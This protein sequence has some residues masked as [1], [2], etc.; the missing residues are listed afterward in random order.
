[1]G[2]LLI[3]IAQVAG[4]AV[5][6]MNP[7]VPVYAYGGMAALFL[8]AV[9]VTRNKYVWLLLASSLSFVISMGA[10]PLS[11]T[12][13]VDDV[14]AYT[15]NRKVAISG[16]IAGS[17]EEYPDREKI[18]LK[19]DRLDNGS[20]DGSR[21]GHGC[22]IQLFAFRKNSGAAHLLRGD[23]VRMVTRL[24]MPKNLNNPGSF[25]YRDSLAKKGI[26]LVAYVN[27]R[28]DIAIDPAMA[29]PGI[30]RS[31]DGARLRIKDVIAKNTGD[32]TVSGIVTALVIGDQGY[33]SRDIRRMFASTGIIH[34]LVVA[35][36]HLAIITH[37]FY[38]LTKFL[39]SRSAYLCG[40]TAIPKLALVM[41]MIPMTAYIFLSGANPPV[42][43]SGIMIAVYGFLFL[44]NKTQTRWTG[45]LVAAIFIL[46]VNP[47]A[48]Y[49][50]SFQLSF[51]AV[52]SI[53]ACMPVITAIG[54]AVSRRF[55]KHGVREIVRSL[56]GMLLI[57]F[58]VT[59]G[60]FGVIAFYFNTL[61]LFGI[62]LNLIV[63][64]F[65]CYL[66]LPLSLI[67]S[68]TGLVLPWFSHY[69]FMIIAAL[70]H[71]IVEIV[72]HGANLPIASIRVPT[73][74]VFEIF[75]YYGGM[76]ILLN[77][78]RMGP[79]TALS[80]LFFIFL[81][82][83]VDIGSFVSKTRFN[84]ELRIT[85]IDVGQGDSALIEF[86][87]GKTM[88][89]DAGGSAYS[90]YDT[91]EAVVA[92]YIWSLKRTRID[93]AVSSHPQE[94]H[95]AGLCFIIKNME[96]K[97]V[98]KSDC[99]PDTAVYRAFME[100]VNESGAA[101]STITGTVETLSVNGVGVTLFSMPHEA[102]DPS[103]R[104]DIN[105]DAVLTMI[106]Y[107][108]VRVLFTGDI[109]KD[110]ERSLAETYR[111][112]LKSDIMK[113]AH[114]GSRTSTSAVFLDAVQPGIVVIPVGRNNRFRMPSKVVLRR[115]F[116]RNIKV[117]RTDRC[118]AITITTDG[119]QIRIK[120]SVDI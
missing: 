80:L 78:K 23:Y 108:D 29:E 113:A 30:L 51:V 111:D 52:G 14:L 89:I 112:A 114:H 33:I 36:L 79:K 118:G 84:K 5:S 73:P 45:I 64:P 110:A 2:L 90:S 107:K 26:G 16:W 35:G 96:V 21:R 67:A 109:E 97:R 19:T 117:L 49:S 101:V 95:M 22:L 20:H 68:A 82:L 69:L 71:A 74:T 37:L 93:Y 81:L 58:F 70:I 91:G 50:I 42:V 31:I 56:T 88:L 6:G 44:I 86:P 41:S 18:L 38:L 102:C 55:G 106:T 43:R 104:K 85:F 57:S 63:I 59:A 72:R 27:N 4:I 53:I 8:C 54:S 32:Q 3:F 47:A 13:C 25:D 75:L 105:N 62:L 92:R 7:S 48:V 15:G 116:K 115:L 9:V 10:S 98:Y 24:R 28:K 83:T 77:F 66:V 119:K 40:H 120:N 61:P 100:A 39:L 1:M 11:S 65:F 60:L 34:I 46:A 103:F 76:I 12:S 99:A 94:D 87:Y 17:V